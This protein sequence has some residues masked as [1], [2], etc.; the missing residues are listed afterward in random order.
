MSRQR[1]ISE[2]AADVPWSSGIS[3]L[4]AVPHAETALVPPGPT[5][6]GRHVPLLTAVASRGGRASRN[7]PS[8]SP[9]P[10]AGQRRVPPVRVKVWGADGKLARAHPPDGEGKNWWRRL[11]NALGT[12]SS[13]FVNASLFQIQAA[14]RSPWGGISELSMNAALAMIEAAA[15]KD[16]IEGALA[17]QMACTHTA[18]MAVLAKLDV[19]FATERR[20]AAFGSA[21]ARLLRAYAMQAEVLRRLRNGGQQVVRVEHVHVNDGGRAVIGNV[22]D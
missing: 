8:N 18:A 15:P 2:R 1:Q 4:S 19:A 13:D 6:C 16:E 11:K 9:A 10:L 12:M 21:A 7:E 20:I 5:S 22:S 14:S 3:L 17:V